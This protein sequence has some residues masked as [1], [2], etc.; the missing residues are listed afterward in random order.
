MCLLVRSWVLPTCTHA[1]THTG[2]SCL[3]LT[4]LCVI[5]PAHPEAESRVAAELDRVLQGRPPTYDDLER[6]P[7]LTQCVKETM[8]LYPA[9]PVFPREA[10]EDDVLP[11][12]HPVKAGELS[13]LSQLVSSTGVSKFE[14][15]SFNRLW[16]LD[17]WIDQ[18]LRLVTCAARGRGVHVVLRAGPV[19]G[20]LARPAAVR[21]RPL[22]P[23][24]QSAAPQV[25]VP[26]LRRRSQ[27]VLGLHL[28]AD[29]GHAHGRHAA[30]EVQVQASAP[31]HAVDTRALR[32]HHEL[33]WDQRAQDASGTTTNL[34]LPLL[35]LLLV[36]LLCH[37]VV[38]FSDCK[39][40]CTL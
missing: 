24:V 20:H 3:W 7:Y 28:R 9:I 8:R 27:D 12:G 18:L 11:T 26:A 17:T 31:H 21:P 19:P 33:Q 36:T 22:L 13:C 16:I 35:G 6:M 37:T 10:K 14:F 39:V 40:G 34:L 2:I 38:N 4:L 23:G 32:H 25:P 1:W 15:A 30:P 29:V 5:S